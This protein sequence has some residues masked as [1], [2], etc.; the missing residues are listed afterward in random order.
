MLD[1]DL[2]EC[3]GLQTHDEREGGEVWM[4]WLFDEPPSQATARQE[5]R[6]GNLR[7]TKTGKSGA[8]CRFYKI[9]RSEATSFQQ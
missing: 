9:R 4:S 1:L 2:V 7:W 6:H 8:S 5:L 3:R